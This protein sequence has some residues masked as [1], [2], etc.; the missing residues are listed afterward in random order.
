MTTFVKTNGQFQ[1][2][3]DSGQLVPI[4]DNPWLSGIYAGTTPYETEQ[5]YS[6]NQSNPSSPGALASSGGTSTPG[7]LRQ[8]RHPAAADPMTTFSNNLMQM[9]TTA[10]KGQQSIDS[11]TRSGI[12][13]MQ[14]QQASDALAYAQSGQLPNSGGAIGPVTPSGYISGINQ[15]GNEYAPAVSNVTQQ[16]SYYDSAMSNFTGLMDEFSKV[17]THT[18][19]CYRFRCGYERIYHSLFLRYTGTEH[20]GTTSQSPA[21]TTI[22]NGPGQ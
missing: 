16:L 13:G 17:G 4:T 8:R 9:L 5:Q 22:Y 14:N 10:Q 18:R 1:A 3:D 12:A 19:L 11:S 21:T 6:A 15:V 2:V 20:F 7:S